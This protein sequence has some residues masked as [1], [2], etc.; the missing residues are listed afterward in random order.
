MASLNEEDWA[1]NIIDWK[2]SKPLAS[3][4]QEPTF[5]GET[6]DMDSLKKK[7]FDALPEAEYKKYLGGKTLK[8]IANDWGVEYHG[9]YFSTS[10]KP[11]DA[12]W[13]EEVKIE[14]AKK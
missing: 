4:P 1:E 3:K 2:T 5:Y 7:F 9:D 8:E 10:E 14:L 13:K 6:Y 12:F 11:K